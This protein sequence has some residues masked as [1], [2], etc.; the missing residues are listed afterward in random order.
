RL[1]QAVPS[2]HAESGVLEQLGWAYIKKARVSYDPGFYKLAE[3]CAICIESTRPDSPEALLLRG[4][5]LDSLHQ[6]KE[7]EAIARR[8]SETRGA[9]FDY[10]LLGD[11]LMEQG[12]LNE[13]IQAYQK[14]IDL[15]PGPQAYTR[16]AHVRW[17]KGD[18]EGSI[19]MMRKAA[20]AMSP[21]DAESAAWAYT[22]LAL[23]ELQA[24]SPKSAE[25][26]CEI[27]LG[28]QNDY[29][30]ALLARSR[31][32]LAENRNAEAAQIMRQAARLN[33]LPEYQWLLA[34]AL[35]AAGRDSEARAVED[36]LKRS[37]AGEDPRTLALFLATRGQQPDLAL[38]LIEQEKKARDDVFTLDALAWALAA[39][40]RANE[41]SRPMQRALAEGTKDA[42]LFYHAGSIAAM[43]GQKREARLLLNRAAAIK[44]MLLP[45]E[46]EELSRA[47][48]KL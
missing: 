41:A 7:A 12:R 8:L 17:L 16:V 36:K 4:H 33:P 15:K 21:R 30:P 38:T 43:N 40:G 23:Y 28:L 32:L 45:S 20:Q 9:P 27:A 1:Q 13:A 5:V 22:R 3:Q 39:T 24:G 35:R 10:G 29:A 6:F 18:L 19:E 11:T 14:M 25:R 34:E 31:V 2:A 46:R 26:A 42:R 48:A 44:Q 47:L 37:G